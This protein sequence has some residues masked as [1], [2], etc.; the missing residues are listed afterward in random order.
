MT[1]STIVTIGSTT[2]IDLRSRRVPIARES[3]CD[4]VNTVSQ[5][6]VGTIQTGIGRGGG[7]H[8]GHHLR[9]GVSREEGRRC[10]QEQG[11]DKPPRLA[12]LDGEIH[13]QPTLVVVKP[14]TSRPKSEDGLVDAVRRTLATQGR[15]D[16]E[17]NS[18]A[19]LISFPK[20]LRIERS[21][22][23]YHQWLA[24]CDDAGMDDP[25]PTMLGWER[26][27]NGTMMSGSNKQCH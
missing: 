16:V 3:R 13:C 23:S 26:I 27:S 21:G 4:D 17:G 2:Y 18:S 24:P 20:L 11:T 9:L 25:P 19:L 22:E 8:E 5:E 14:G 15:G 10:T 1:I 12:G 7:N 6:P